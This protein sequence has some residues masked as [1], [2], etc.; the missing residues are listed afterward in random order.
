M[1]P[2]LPRGAM[3]LVPPGIARLLQQWHLSP[4]EVLFDFDQVRLNLLAEQQPEPVERG[5]AEIRSEMQRLIA[6]LTQAITHVDPTLVQSALGTH[7]RMLNELERLERKTLKA[8]ERQSSEQTERLERVRKVLFP[9]RGLQERT[10]NIFCL[11]AR[12]G[13]GLL[14]QLQ[15]LLDGEEGRHLFVEL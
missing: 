4:L 5:F 9:W 12:Y 6:S 8:I 13:P 3:T 1:P 11:L 10:L 14:D 15:D 2:V 7:Q